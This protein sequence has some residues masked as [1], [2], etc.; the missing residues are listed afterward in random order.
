MVQIAALKT[1]TAHLNLKI[2]L[3]ELCVD[4]N[5]FQSRIFT[6]D[7]ELIVVKAKLENQAKHIISSEVEFSFGSST[8]SMIDTLTYT[9]E[10]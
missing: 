5:Q 1:L 2:F 3:M 6:L 10:P 9:E 4:T 8:L 7:Y